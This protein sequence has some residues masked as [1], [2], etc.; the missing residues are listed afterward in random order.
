MF[1]CVLV[2]VGVCVC[3]CLKEQKEEP[4]GS[5]GFPVCVSV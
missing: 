5:L 4:T 1:L 2:S 3:Q